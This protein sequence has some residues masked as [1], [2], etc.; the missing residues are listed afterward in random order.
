MTTGIRF[1]DADRHTLRYAVPDG[2]PPRD[3]VL[4]R[5]GCAGAVH[6]P[7]TFGFVS[8]RINRH[9]HSIGDMFGYFIKSKVVS[10]DA[11]TRI[12]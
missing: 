4:D 12:T 10:I 11:F 8:I 5:T 6:V 3:A 9:K 7:P 1:F 2:A